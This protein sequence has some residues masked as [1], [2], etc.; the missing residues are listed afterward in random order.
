MGKLPFAETIGTLITSSG[1]ALHD[2]ETGTWSLF[3]DIFGGIGGAV[4]WGIA[5][6]Y[7]V[8][9]FLHVSNIAVLTLFRRGGGAQC[10]SLQVFSLLC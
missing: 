9:F 5:L 10:A 8:I 4:L 3:N 7:W 1:Q 2:V 6:L